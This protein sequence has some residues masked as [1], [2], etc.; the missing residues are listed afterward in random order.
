MKNLDILPDF[1][2]KRLEFGSV[3]CYQ[4][5]RSLADELAGGMDVSDPVF[6]LKLMHYIRELEPT[7]APLR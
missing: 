2:P 5:Q 3:P 6:F 7:I 4:Y 1:T